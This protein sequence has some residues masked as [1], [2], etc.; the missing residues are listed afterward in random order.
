M[1][2][3]DNRLKRVRLK[4]ERDYAQIPNEWLRDPKLSLGARGLLGLLMSHRD[5]FVISYKSL[6]ASNPEGV[7]AITRMVQELKEGLYLSI[8]KERNPR[9]HIIGYVWELTDPAEQKTRSHPYLDYPYTGNPDMDN[10]DMDNRVLKEAHLEEDLN[11][12]LNQIDPSTRAGMEV[13]ALAGDVWTQPGVVHN[14]RCV[15]GHELIEGTDYCSIACHAH[16]EYLQG[17]VGA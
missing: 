10:P 3:G 11:T 13:D 6:A 16:H 1:A 7:T 17:L 4:F 9:G 5:G 12:R 8:A 2:V 15:A 14:T